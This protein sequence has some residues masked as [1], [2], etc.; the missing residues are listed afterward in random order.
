[1]DAVK[2]GWQMKFSGHMYGKPKMKFSS[3]IKPI[4]LILSICLFILPLKTKAQGGTTAY[5]FLNIPSSSFVFGSGGVNIS[6]LHTDLNLADQN[7]ALIGPENDKELK[8]GYMHYYGSSN[9]GSVRF[10]MAAGERGAWAAGLR[11]LNYGTFSGY[12]PDGSYTGSFSV[13]DVI[14]EG[15]YSHDFTYRLRGG[16]NVK[17]IYSGYEQYTA[18][19]M[20]AD[21]GLCYYDD[22]HEISVGFVLKNMGGQLK[23]FEEKYNRLPFDVELGITKGFK[24]R[25]S[26]SITAWHLTKWNLP[27]YVHEDGEETEQRNSGFFRNLF[28]HLVFGLD[29]T[30]SERFYINL[31]YNYKTASDMASYQRNFFSGFSIGTGFNVRAF[32]LGVAFGMPHKGAATLLLNLGLDINELL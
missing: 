25:F 1:M 10:G 8:V 14:L 19:A 27:Y 3:K 31:G 9:F 21:L 30:P 26:F 11:Y 17:M 6:T 12:E 24:D 4:S 32:S 29:F 20:A 15:T 18:F 7:P 5:D 28:R 13:Q 22:D 23:R 2:I 16:I